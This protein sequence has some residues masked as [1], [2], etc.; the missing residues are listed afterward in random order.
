MYAGKEMLE[1]YNYDD[2]NF[3]DQSLFW[4][5]IKDYFKRKNKLFI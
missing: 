1:F 4:G 2:F 3:E 5:N